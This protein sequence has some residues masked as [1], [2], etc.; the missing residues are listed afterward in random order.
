MHKWS[1]HSTHP[2]LHTNNHTISC[3]FNLEKCLADYSL[4]V[5]WKSFFFMSA[6]YYTVN[7]YHKSSILLPKPG[8]LGSFQ[9]F[10]TTDTTEIHKSI[11]GLSPLLHLFWEGLVTK[12]DL[13]ILGEDVVFWNTH[14]IFI[15]ASKQLC[16]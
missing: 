8:H 3:F 2:S 6:Q 14:L 11:F 4:T 16:S 5:W 15:H 13:W 10:A 1:C 7:M 9:Y 12:L